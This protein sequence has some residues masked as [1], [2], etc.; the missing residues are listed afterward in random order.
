MFG[1]TAADPLTAL[2]SSF[3]STKGSWLWTWPGISLLQAPHSKMPHFQPRPCEEDLWEH[4]LRLHHP[5]V[6]HNICIISNPTR[7]GGSAVSLPCAFSFYSYFNRAVDCER[8]PEVSEFQR[9]N[10][11]QFCADLN[12]NDT[13]LG[14]GQDPSV[15]FRPWLSFK[16]APSRLCSVWSWEGSLLHSSQC[17]YTHLCN[18]WLICA[19]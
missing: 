19:T 18:I 3:S 10:H 9:E 17:C 2:V 16:S 12:S 11:W 15:C 8:Q 1:F 4:N 7:R 13:I 14:C 6:S 5:P